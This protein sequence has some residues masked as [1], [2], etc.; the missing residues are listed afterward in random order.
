MK[1]NDL[2]T[3]FCLIITIWASPC[4]SAEESSN[5]DA[6]QAPQERLCLWY[7][8]PAKEWT[9]ALP[10]GNGRLGAMVFGGVEEERLQL[11]EDTLW[12][13]GPYDP[14]NPAA[15]A[16]LPEVRQLIFESKY[17]EATRLIDRQVMAR[18]LR[19]MPYQTVGDLLLR[20]PDS[21]PVKNYRRELNLDTAIARVSYALGDVS[22]VREVFASPVDQVLVVRLTA[23]RDGQISFTARLRTPQKATVTVDSGDTLVM[24]G[25]NGGAEGIPGA[26]KFQA[27]LRVVTR[28][29]ET[30]TSDDE[31]S[32][33]NADSALLLVAA[34]T[35]YKSFNDVGGD[36]EA[37][38]KSQIALAVEKDFDTLRSAHVDAHQ[39]LFRRVSLDLGTSEDM[40]KPTDERIK[41]FPAANDPQFAELYFQ[42]G[43]YLLISSSRPGTQPAGLQGIWNESMAPPWGGKYTININTEMNYWPAEPCNLAECVEPLIRM[44]SELAETG[45]TTA[46]DMYGA[47]GWVTHHNTDLWRATAP[48]DGPNWGMWPTGG[49]WLCL[50]LWDRYA[51]SG[52]RAY[53]KSVYPVLKGAAEFFLDTLVEDPKHKWLVTNPSLSPENQHPFGAAVC[54]G[55]TMDEQIIR[56]LFSNC[57]QAAEV[58]D[59][60]AEFRQ[61]LE[62]KR[63]RLAP[64]QVGKGGQLQEWLEDWDLEAPEQ[65]HRHISHLYGLY[66][67]AQ[68]TPRQTPELAEAAKVTLNTRGDLSTGWAI[69]WRINC[70]ARLHD[71]D[72]TFYILKNLF[73]P[74]R[75]YPNMFDA[76]PPFQIDGNFGGTSGIVEMLLQS[77]A[78]EIE[79]LPALPAEWPAGRVK[80]LRARGGFEV[81]MDWRDGKLQSALFRNHNGERAIVRYGNQTINIESPRDKIIRLDSSLMPN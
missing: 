69:A 10:I 47:R 60:D 44:V 16:A 54:A 11:N 52:D 80:G 78:G 42:Y 7:R 46:K 79:L 43:R 39:S 49:A 66:P 15:K 61:E 13:G 72:R 65:Q 2:V 73:S 20:F 58:L 36:P 34:A 33:R 70:W 35:S 24:Q 37:V 55:P 57:I 23:D 53:L 8:Q 19:Q 14:V 18:P 21:A 5:P 45:A 4:R 6:A 22:F 17:R 29:G 59:V 48:I 9:E 56:D 12:A 41:A 74:S 30:V 77:H 28:G 32:V 25:V 26:L 76:H 40:G 67:S 1:I 75:T 68:I 81:D 63:S 62:T 50:H 27:R 71:G 3:I 64:N 38:T 51:Y 31:I